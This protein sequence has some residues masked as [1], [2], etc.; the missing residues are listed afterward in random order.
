M[1]RSVS[2]ENTTTTGQPTPDN[3][4]LCKARTLSPKRKRDPSTYQL[5]PGTPFDQSILSDEGI[6]LPTELPTSF[7][8]ALDSVISLHE[9]KF[10][11]EISFAL[12]L[13]RL[14]AYQSVVSS[15]V[16]RTGKSDVLR[17]GKG[18]FRTKKKDDSI[19][20]R[21]VR[22]TSLNLFQNLSEWFGTINR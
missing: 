14:E 10:C 1:F 11:T 18:E 3:E 13:L 6:E 4:K 19:V 2:S 12:S 16:S 7:A 22:R 5:A 20:P 9:T 21:M 17:D 15:S 8:L